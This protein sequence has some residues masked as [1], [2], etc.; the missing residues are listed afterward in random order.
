MLLYEITEE[1][2]GS[3]GIEKS[4]EGCIYFLI[5]TNWVH[6]LT[7]FR[8]GG[9]WFTLSELLKINGIENPTNR[10][11]AE[12][13]SQY[14]GTDVLGSAGFYISTIEMEQP[15]SWNDKFKNQLF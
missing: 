7:E 11:V 2:H 3:I 6:G 15:T 13:L 9:K 1:S 8:I 4:F 10:N 14:E 12:Y 5:S